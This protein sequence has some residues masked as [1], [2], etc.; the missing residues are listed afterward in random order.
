MSLTHILWSSDTKAECFHGKT[1]YPKSTVPKTSAPMSY[2][3]LPLLKKKERKEKQSI[4]WG[5]Q[6]GHR[7]GKV[8]L[9]AGGQILYWVVVS[10]RESHSVSECRNLAGEIV[11]Q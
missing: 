6:D 7:M 2:K 10:E 1:T 4:Y 3:V 8:I 9:T 5:L 11:Y